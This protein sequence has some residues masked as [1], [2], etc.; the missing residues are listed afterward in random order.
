ML[1]HTCIES[2][3]MLGVLG[4]VLWSPTYT[5]LCERHGYRGSGKPVPMDYVDM[6]TKGP[7]AFFCGQSSAYLLPHLMLT[8]PWML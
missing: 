4:S 3:E 2:L 8:R 7:G 1:H 6:G 5:I